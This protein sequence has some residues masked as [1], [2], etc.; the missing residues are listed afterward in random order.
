M[1]VK[2]I[3]TS[4]T[5]WFNVATGAVSY[6]GYLPSK[7]AMPVAVVGNILLRFITKQPVT[8]TF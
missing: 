3:F 4:K 6:S 1:N 5:F 7:Y 2:S 8:I